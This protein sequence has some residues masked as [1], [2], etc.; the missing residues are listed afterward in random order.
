[1]GQ[2]Q[3]PPPQ[4][5]ITRNET[6]VMTS[7]NKNNLHTVAT[8]NGRSEGSKHN[9]EIPAETEFSDLLRPTAKTALLSSQTQSHN[10]GQHK[11]NHIIK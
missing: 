1:M 7:S 9:L 10:M 6:L 5:N 3:A 11:P 2:Q 8:L 4:N